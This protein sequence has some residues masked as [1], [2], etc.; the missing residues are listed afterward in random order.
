MALTPAPTPAP[1][2]GDRTTFRDR[3][4]AFITWLILLVGQLND[5]LASLTSIAAGGGFSLGYTF[6]SLTADADPTPGVLRFNNATQNATTVLRVDLTSGGQDVTAILDA[7]DDSGSLVKGQLRL[8]NLN[9]P[10]KW[11]VFNLTSTASPAG[12]RN[13]TV[14]VIS[15]SGAN[16]FADGNS[17]ALQFTRSGDVGT[18]GTVLRRSATAATS[19]T[20]TPNSAS[21]DIFV[22]TALAEAANFQAPTGAP[23]QGQQLQIRIKDNGTVRALAFNAIYRSSS[24][25]ILPS[26]TVANKTLYLGFEYNV[27]AVK[28]DFIAQLNNF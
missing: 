8:V 15:A 13:F 19:A 24:D 1:Q 27:E 10:T 16:P 25:L 26:T 17:L 7:F 21:T 12:Y 23:I 6:S 9:D 14:A 5:F 22:L 3:V 20:P 4:D 18:P 28:W 11:I 2:R